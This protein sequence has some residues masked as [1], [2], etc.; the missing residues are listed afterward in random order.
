MS[1]KPFDLALL[2]TGHMTDLPGRAEPRFPEHAEPAAWLAIRSAIEQARNRNKGR[3]VGI[4]SGARGGDLL[5]HE[6]CRLFGI[7][8]R[9]VLPFPP[10]VFIETSVAGIPNGGWETKFADNWGSLQ[11][12]E[13]EILLTA[14]DPS[15]Y[16]MCN[17]RMIALAQELSNAYEVVALWDGK[18]G[19]GPGGTAEH[20]ETVRRM[21]G[22]VE[23]IDTNRLLR[24]AAAN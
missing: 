12:S 9:M 15:G 19:D 20:V 18:A 5:F 14:K 8:R 1:Q 23:I 13:R 22:R 10:E 21:G 24:G 17:H 6:A 2:F 7:E 4:A 11:P 3:M 16:A